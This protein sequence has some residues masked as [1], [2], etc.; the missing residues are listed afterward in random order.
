MIEKN[1]PTN[2]KINEDNIKNKN[3]LKCIVE[4]ITRMEAKVKNVLEEVE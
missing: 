2:D 1:Y 4:N 3:L